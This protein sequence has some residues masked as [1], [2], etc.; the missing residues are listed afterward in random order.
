MG[1]YDYYDAVKADL[2]EY[3]KEIADYESFYYPDIDHIWDDS[4]LYNRITGN[5]DG[6]YYCNTYLAEEALCHNWNLL[7]EVIEEYDLRNE[8]VIK[9]GAE[10]CDVLVRDYVL[11]QI[12]SEYD[13]IEELYEDAGISY[14]S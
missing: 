13:S 5:I 4:S 2:F 7:F 8:N 14:N 3:L 1:I 12:L 10:Y 6:S 9:R 11:G